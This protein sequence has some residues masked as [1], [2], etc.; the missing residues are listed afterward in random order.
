M[1]VTARRWTAPL[2]CVALLAVA[3][4]VL[5]A[6]ALAAVEQREL[7]ASPTAA[8]ELDRIIV[9]WEPGTTS[10]ERLDGRDDA[11]TTLVRTLG[12]TA[13]QLVSPQTGQSV[14][15]ALASLGDD[16]NVRAVARDSL[17]VLHAVPNDSLFDQL[18][19]LRNLG[20]GIDGF[21]GAVVGDD[22]DAPAAWDRTVGTPTT[23][24]ADIDSGY[25]FDNP[26]LAGVAWTNPLDPANG[27][28]DDGNGI[29]DD[30][31][32]ADFVGSSADAPTTD[33]NPTDDNLIDGGHGVHTAGTMG[34][35]GNDGAGI[36]GV[37]RNVR[38][39]PLRVC[40]YS[41]LANRT[42]CADSSIIAAI[43]YAGRHGA[44][45]ANLS[46]GGTSFDAP[47]R[48][49]FAVNPRTLYV[50]SAGN[51]AQ[52]NDPGGT[53]HY[54][55]AYDPS[56]SGIGGAIDNVVCVAATDQA[57]ALASFSDWGATTVDLGAPGTEILSV[58]PQI[59]YVTET[60][61][62]DDFA[63]KWIATGADGGFARTNE[64][65][66]T[67]FGMSDSPGA[68]PVAN[69]VRESTSGPISLPS[70]FTQCRLSQVRSVS[71]GGGV[72]TYSILLDGAQL[73]S[74]RPGS[75]AGLAAFTLDVT[76]GL[77]GGG[78]LQLRF[79]Y[80]AGA[81]PTRTDG[82]WLDNIRFTCV[83]PVGL[84]TNYGFLD[85]TSMAAPHVTGAA[86]LLF[87]LKPT[88][89]VTEVKNA[90]LSSGDADSALSGRTVTGK[91]L[92]V[93]RALDALVPP[94]SETVAPETAFTSA[95]PVQTTGTSAAFSFRRTDADL[96]S[97]ECRLDGAAFQ[98]C[99]SPVS[100][101]VG[102]GAHAFEV[103]ALDPFGHV[104]PTPASATW[105]VVAPIAGN[106]GGGGTGDV[107]HCVVPRLAGLSLTRAKAKLRRA[108]CAL[109]RVTKPR[110]RRG[111]RL[112]SLVVKSTN[113]GA[114]ARR[115]EGT[116]VKLTL[117]PKP[118]PRRHHRRRR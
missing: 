74:S 53:P 101:T 32:G 37:A 46:L 43:N 30:T 12:R 6:G 2:A 112:P 71:L 26:D 94:G 48:D 33:G 13:F 56:T 10:V 64:S 76:R 57:D 35:S 27:V 70:G 66:L 110:A 109:G 114:G 87:S 97:F 95:A 96:A 4:L 60:F 18:W 24:I 49:A 17:N 105:T 28:D 78:S 99:S 11:D 3:A 51:D 29:V 45:A 38:I 92:N 50:I 67:S 52:S 41:P 58:Y 100:L 77:S 116:K 34:A 8:G 108:H 81:A 39:M 42:G 40:A 82:V 86:G 93:A 31:H 54:P 75:S 7:A 55:C 85:G 61:T 5:P 69:S 44:R 9:E 79:R 72:Y 68:T 21:G 80:S 63:S 111:R 88:A 22:I 62:V 84:S 91:R 36:S 20:V 117:A 19:G 103:R 107:V 16:P 83:Q 1:I 59:A 102:L 115:A 15:D 25:R 113:P 106:G 73:A 98:L 14:A 90:L 47:T 89:T 23:V 65:P 118:R 104:D